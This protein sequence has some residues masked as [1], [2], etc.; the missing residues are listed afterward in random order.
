LKI[1][2]SGASGLLGS[3][4]VEMANEKGFEIFSGYHKKI[5]QFGKPLEFDLKNEALV[6]KTLVSINPDVIFHCAA[7]TNVDECE[8]NNELARKI[9]GEGPGFI[10][11]A[12]E[13]IGA[14]MAYI[15]T[16][17][18]FD[19]SKGM[20]EETD[21]TRPIN[22]YGYTKLLGE[23]AVIGS[24]TN[25]LI[26]RTSVIYGQSP[27]SG[28]TNFALWLLNNLRN[29][30]TVKVLVDQFVSPT[31]NTNLVDMLLEASQRRLNGIYHMSGNSRVSRYEFAMKLAE[32]FD[33]NKDL[34]EKINMN[35]INWVAKRP[36]DSSLNILKVTES[37]NTKPLNLSKSLNLLKEELFCSKE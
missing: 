8:S 4:V 14:Y 36:K 1:F 25:C 11:K 22:F 6:K 32:V 10:A 27:A 3:R 9:N 29:N 2:V 31:L 28:K 33:L 7:L 20:Y 13:Q 15:S 19:G 18:V 35:E 17:Y 30:N 34:I 16:D 5:P 37:L 21:E 12:A 24:G 26:A 23:K